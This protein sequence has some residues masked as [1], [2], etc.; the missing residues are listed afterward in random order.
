MELNTDRLPEI[1]DPSLDKDN[2]VKDYPTAAR[3][4]YILEGSPEHGEAAL[5]L[6]GANEDYEYVLARNDVFNNLPHFSAEDYKDTIKRVVTAF[7]EAIKLLIKRIRESN[8]EQ[9]AELEW[10][11]MQCV[12]IKPKTYSMGGDSD[13]VKVIKT[14][15]SILSINYQSIDSAEKLTSAINSFSALYTG[16]S[17]YYY[18]QLLPKIG[19]FAAYMRSIRVVDLTES[20]IDKIIRMYGELSSTNLISEMQNHFLPTTP[21]LYRSKALIGSKRIYVGVRE[22]DHSLIPGGNFAKLGESESNPKPIPKE[23]QFRTASSQAVRNI[24]D[25]VKKLVE[26]VNNNEKRQRERLRILESLTASIE[27]LTRF[28][29]VDELKISKTQVEKLVE[30]CKNVT[31]KVIAPYTGLNSTAIDVCKASLMLCQRHV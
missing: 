23:I 13:K 24:I 22:L 31:N 8:I 26:D 18:N 4:Q 10:I 2:I 5:R 7:I 14:H 6:F 3:L 1:E 30:V 27:T 21:D 15:T 11:K 16:Y 9:L 20:D 19:Q 25:Q 17:R 12:L 28:N 29:N